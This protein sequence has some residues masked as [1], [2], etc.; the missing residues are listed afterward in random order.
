[1]VLDS[2]D[3]PDNHQFM[4]HIASDGT[5]RT[6]QMNKKEDW[7]TL[8]E[9]TPEGEVRLRRQGDTI[10]LNDGFQIGELEIDKYGI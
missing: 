2:N 7:R 10:R 4:I 3:E 6:S 9:M 1:G 5:Y 8:F